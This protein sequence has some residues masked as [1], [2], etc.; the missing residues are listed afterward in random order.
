MAV[1]NLNRIFRP[2]SV[3]VVGASDKSSSIGHAVLNNL[4][5]AE[6]P[7]EIYPV[8]PKHKRLADRKCYANV[9]ALPEA[10]DLA[11]VCAPALVVPEIVRQCGEAGAIGTGGTFSRFS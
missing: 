8:N 7:G 1:R 2:K 6:F 9:D 10:P 3:A 5:D 11:V 4:I